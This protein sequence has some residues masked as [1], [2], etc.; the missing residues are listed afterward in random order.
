[1]CQL[2][3]WKPGDLSLGDLSQA[4][5]ARIPQPGVFSQDSLAQPAV[6]SQS[7]WGPRWSH[8][9]F[10]VIGKEG[11]YAA[12]SSDAPAMATDGL[13][14]SLDFMIGA[15]RQKPC[16]AAWVCHWGFLSTEAGSHFRG[17]HFK[18]LSNEVRQ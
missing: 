15:T 7:V 14:E 6:S 10:F 4:S 11:G 8:L 12:S 16:Q 1:M 18:L 17:Q 2:A 5:S 3:A 9:L 13:E